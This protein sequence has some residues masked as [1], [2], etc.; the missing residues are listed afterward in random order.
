MGRPNGPETTTGARVSLLVG[1]CSTKILEICGGFLP[2][3]DL[4]MTW[5]LRIETF[6]PDL[7][8]V[9]LSHSGPSAR[10]LASPQENCLVAGSNMWS[11]L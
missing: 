6:I 4:V 7:L 10:F 8:A 2:I 11:T 9:L 5:L 1:H 3:D